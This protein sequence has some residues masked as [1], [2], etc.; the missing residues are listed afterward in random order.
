[1]KIETV[2]L[3]KYIKYAIRR[4]KPMAT[5]YFSSLSFLFIHTH[6]FSITFYCLCKNS[7]KRNQRVCNN[8]Q[9]SSS[10]PG[11]SLF[12]SRNICVSL[13]MINKIDF[14]TNKNAINSTTGTEQTHLYFRSSKNSICNI[15]RR[16]TNP[17]RHLTYPQRKG[18][19]RAD[20]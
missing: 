1:M 13:K 20:E 3:S 10:F 9:M 18:K 11:P 14:C 7:M 2:N 8:P 12:F 6:T 4:R 5:K 19:N 16:P 17:L 15:S